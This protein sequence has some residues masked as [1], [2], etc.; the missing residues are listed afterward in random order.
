MSRKP[1]RASLETFDGFVANAAEAELRV[2][3][4]IELRKPFKRTDSVVDVRLLDA[5]LAGL[6]TQ[7]KPRGKL[8]V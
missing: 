5:V 7:A 8:H 3:L 2:A 6:T 4:K 1:Q